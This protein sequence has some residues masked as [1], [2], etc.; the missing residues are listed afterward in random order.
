RQEDSQ[1]PSS[2]TAPEGKLRAARGEPSRQDDL[3]DDLPDDLRDTS[4]Q[5][6]RQGDI[7]AVA[8][9]EA[10]P[11]GIPLERDETARRDE[12]R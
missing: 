5:T 10:P 11:R 2:E 3:R 7:R 12:D 6:S 4:A 8:G 9:G 1:A